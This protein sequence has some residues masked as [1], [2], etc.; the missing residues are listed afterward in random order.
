[1]ASRRPSGADVW[2]GV[3][4]GPR[5]GDDPSVGGDGHAV[6]AA[7]GPEVVEDAGV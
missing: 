5:G 7:P 6:G 4:A 2:R 3:R 1:M